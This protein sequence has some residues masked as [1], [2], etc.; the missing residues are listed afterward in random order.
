MKKLF[1]IFGLV[2]LFMMANMTSSM[3]QDKPFRI[4]LKFG[5][6]QVA[7]LNFEYVTPMM[8]KK[9][10]ADLDLSYFSFSSGAATVSYMNFAI[11]ADYYFMREGK[12]LYGGLAFGRSSFSATEDVTEAT[13]GG[14]ASA[15]G[16]LGLNTLN[17]KIGGKHGG[18]FY[19]RWE[20]GYRVALNSATLVETATYPDGT[21]YRNEISLPVSGG[22]ILFDLGF[23]L[24][25]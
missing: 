1:T 14:T 12:G 4:G 15:K 25:F 5:I 18:L 17:L 9:L 3:A 11:G 6:P 16:T 2:G 21:P 8:S 10:S 22:G 13:S 19:F 7:G 20:L 24:A 23:G